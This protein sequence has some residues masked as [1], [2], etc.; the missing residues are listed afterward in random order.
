MGCSDNC[1]ENTNNFLA[2]CP[3]P[4]AVFVTLL[5]LEIHW[6]PCCLVAQSCLTLCDPM[7]CSTPGLP[8]HHQLPV[9]S[10]SCP[11]SWW[12]HPTSSSSVIPFSSRLQSFPASGSFLRSRLF[13]SGGQSIGVSASASI[14]PMNIQDWFPLGLTGLISLQSNWW[15]RYT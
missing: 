5:N 9:Y 4:P 13:A 10:N 12:C 15:A 3:P 6:W 7:D 1:S 8:V 2:W 11:S 14:L